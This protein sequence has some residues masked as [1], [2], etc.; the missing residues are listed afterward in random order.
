MDSSKKPEVDQFKIVRNEITLMGSFIGLNTLPATVAI[1]ESGIVDFS[2]LITHRLPL[3]AFQIGLD[4][5]RDG[6]AIE[7]ILYPEWDHEQ[8]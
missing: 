8:N 2:P 4:A 1:M 7:V 6:S 3:K 5:M